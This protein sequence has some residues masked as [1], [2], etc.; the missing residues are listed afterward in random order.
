[1]GVSEDGGDCIFNGYP[2]LSLWQTCQASIVCDGEFPGVCALFTGSCR[3]T[4]CEAVGTSSLTSGIRR[5]VGSRAG[6]IT[7]IDH[8][9]EGRI[10]KVPVTQPCSR[11]LFSSK[12]FP[13][14]FFVYLGGEKSLNGTVPPCRG[15]SVC[16]RPDAARACTGSHLFPK[17]RIPAVSHAHVS[18]PIDTPR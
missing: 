2:P 4:F 11:P 13:F 9:Q 7:P 10:L 12:S 3:P 17:R 15:I 8:G 5:S 16:E 18:I 14:F 1:M 6:T